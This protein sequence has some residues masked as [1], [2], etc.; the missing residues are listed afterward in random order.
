MCSLLETHTGRQDRKAPERPGCCDST[1]RKCLSPGVAE[2]DD[3]GFALQDGLHGR[4]VE[5]GCGDG[6]GT[7]VAP[8]VQHSIPAG[9]RWTRSLLPPSR[10]RL[11]LVIYPAAYVAQGRAGQLGP[12][13]DRTLVFLG[14]K[15]FVAEALARHHDCDDLNWVTVITE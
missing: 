2:A 6:K 13:R 5:L 11:D 3:A 14:H 1:Q 12:C 10:R 9:K 7:G 15:N 4:A 8:D